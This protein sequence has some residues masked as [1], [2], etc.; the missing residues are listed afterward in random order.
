MAASKDVWMDKRKVARW[1][2]ERVER[3]APWK[4]PLSGLHR[5]DEMV[6]KWGI[7]LVVQWVCDGVDSK[8][9]QLGTV[10]VD[11]MAEYLVAWKVALKDGRMV[12][13]KVCPMERRTVEEMVR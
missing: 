7:V 2:I 8:A 11:A 4:D 5:V 3:K 9:A 10:S 6:G 12:S 13:Q 1:V